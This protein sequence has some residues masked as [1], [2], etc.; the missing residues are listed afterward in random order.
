MVYYSN[1]A[2]KVL[3]VDD[4]EHIRKLIKYNLEKNGYKTTAVATGEEALAAA[5]AALPDIIVLDVML[6][7]LDGLDV[8]RL[9]SEDSR[10]SQIPILMVTARGADEDIVSGLEAGAD[11]Y[12][13][14]PFSPK[15]L[16]ARVNAI[17]RRNSKNMNT[18]G[19]E[20][21]VSIHGIL[22]DTNK[23][24]LSL[25]GHPVIMSTTEF[26]I[27]ELLCRNP[28][29]VLSRNQII[30]AVKGENYPVTERSVD[31]QILGVR[32]KLGN[33]GKY[34]ETV[35]GIGYRIAEETDETES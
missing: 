8:C 1:M 27:L 23:H 5:F 20:S 4:E 16:S 11:D 30:T 19:S 13:V 32:K 15:I 10:T 33:L 12:I 7:G 21:V 29:W 26:A 9:L 31:V 3:I 28:G 14:K 22:I 6:P 35:R 18:N 2:K 25:D 24:E 17:L 34:L